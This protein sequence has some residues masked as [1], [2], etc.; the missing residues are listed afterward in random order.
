MKVWLS[1]FATEGMGSGL[2]AI[3]YLLV[4][5][6]SPMPLKPGM[7]E[8]LMGFGLTVGALLLAASLVSRINRVLQILAL[9]IVYLSIVPLITGIARGN[10]LSDM[11]RDFLPLMFITTLPLLIGYSQQGRDLT[12]QIRIL[13]GV[14]VAVGVVSAL[15]F[16]N[17]ILELFGS[18]EMY[19]SRYTHR[20][21]EAE[22]TTNWL[23]WLLRP[24]GL[25][26][27]EYQTLLVKCQDPAL[28]FA[29]IYLG[30][31]G[32]S[33][34]LIKPRRGLLG[35]GA[36][37]GGG[38]CAYAFASL[39][40]RAF[41][42]LL[43]LSV[44]LFVVHLIKY[45]R[46]PFWV[47]MGAAL[48]LLLL[49]Y[50]PLSAL[51]SQMWAKQQTEGLSGRHLEVFAVMDSIASSKD[52]LLFGVGWGG[53]FANPIYEAASTRYT[54][55]LFT[56]WLLKTGIIG[57]LVMVFFVFTLCRQLDLRGV[58]VSGHR[59]AILLATISVVLI[60]LLFEPTYKMLSFGM[61]LGVCLAVF[62]RTPSVATGDDGSNGPRQG[63]EIGMGN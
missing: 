7:A 25:E 14:I 51:I 11:A 13:L 12:H 19:L 27:L 10:E 39:G 36:L 41:S 31:L 5:F 1:R 21:V 54:H 48:V 18:M 59:L 15:Q 61:V 6:S 3:S 34:V 47:L 63:D 29:A 2:I 8:A 42:A 4:V 33:F 23:A 58:W 16:Y 35:L 50:D 38:L 9:C 62:I 26:H 56:Y 30:C 17:G 20:P 49:F 24:L 40:M 53:T 52:K 57:C 32:M 46:F 44:A 37:G 22:N 60:G 28:L 43:A 45:R 55:S